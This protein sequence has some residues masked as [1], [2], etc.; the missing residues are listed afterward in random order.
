MS[1]KQ[2]DVQKSR[3]LSPKEKALYPKTEC[4]ASI[5]AEPGKGKL[6][7]SQIFRK[8]KISSNLKFKISKLPY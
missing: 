7:L 6:P 5:E 3:W 4:N 1:F 8:V 2:A